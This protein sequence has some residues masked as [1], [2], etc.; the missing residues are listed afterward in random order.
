MLRAKRPVLASA[1]AC[2]LV[3]SST[4]PSL[5]LAAST[6]EDRPGEIAMIGDALIA[7]PVLLAS[8]VIGFGLFVV[9]LPASALG[10]N[11]QEAAN[12]LVAAPGKATFMRCLGCTPAQDESLRAQ[13]KT[14][15]ANKEL[16]KQDA[17]K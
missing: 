11:V 2:T 4:A 15:K 1:L 3:L 7:R 9:T 13:R 14:D 8:T 17:S 12:T 10:G 16:A 5:G 6:I